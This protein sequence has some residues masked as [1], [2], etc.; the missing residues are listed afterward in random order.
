VAVTEKH[1]RL[2]WSML[3]TTIV[4]AI[5]VFL[6][7]DLKPQVDQNFFFS[8]SDP[9]FQEDNKIDQMFPS[10]S[11]LI[12]SVSSSDI[13]S[14]LYLDRLSRF[15]QQIA[16]IKGVTGVRSLSNGPKDFKDAKKS[17]FWRRLLIAENERSSNVIVFVPTQNSEGLIRQLE[18]I[19]D[20][21]NRKGF[22][23]HIAGAPYAA[24]MIR[25]SL[26]HDF[27]YFSLAAVALARHRAAAGQAR[28]MCCS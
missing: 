7:V 2:R 22:R 18:V 14:H 10:G 11:Q 28:S 23:I 8:S 24:E 12:V 27:R 15:T 25:R 16:S 9:Q 4:L 1:S 3:G 20:K 21:F 13:S 5:L 6:F 17:P 19:V 26:L